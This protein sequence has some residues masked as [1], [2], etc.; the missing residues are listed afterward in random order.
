MKLIQT[1]EYDGYTN[2]QTAANPKNDIIRVKKLITGGEIWRETILPVIVKE[3]WQKK[4]ASVIDFGCGLG[5]N[6]A[7]LREVFPQQQVA[8]YDLE[9]M[10]KRLTELY[11]KL[12][13]VVSWD[14][15][16]LLSRMQTQQICIFECVVWQ[17]IL[18][19]SNVVQRIIEIF[20][21]TPSITSIYT[22]WNAKVA[23]QTLFIQHM[24]D[25]GWKVEVTG[26]LD[27]KQKETLGH[28]DHNWYLFKKII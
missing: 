4:S 18:W 12:Y 11:P 16:S 1:S 13:D 23:H 21:K 3:Y 27:E 28:V 7:M 5:R 19:E 25:N 26:D 24:V 22:V 10:I 15:V 20:N 14:L 9:L 17:H 2:W 6:A 8:G